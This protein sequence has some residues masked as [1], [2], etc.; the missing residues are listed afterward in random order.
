[1]IRVR[2]LSLALVLAWAACSRSSP[3]NPPSPSSIDPALEAAA[4]E[5]TR[6]DEPMEILFDWNLRERD[7]RFSGEGVARIEPDRARV[8][9]FGPRGEGY[10]SAVL[11]G[12]QLKLSLGVESVPLPPP[13]LFWS[14]LGVFRVPPGATLA[15]AE[16]KDANTTLEYAASGDAWRFQLDNGALQHAEWTGSSAGRRTVELSRNAN[17][18]L[19]SGAL[20]RD[21]PAFLELRLTPKQVRKV[22][23]FPAEIWTVRR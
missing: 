9:L 21:W 19:P 23:G 13:A 22:N 11:D 14:V 4:V 5:R 2:T 18:E 10:L 20:Y 15:R 16:Q 1:M 8:D 12:F 17:A 3:P 7:A 6:V